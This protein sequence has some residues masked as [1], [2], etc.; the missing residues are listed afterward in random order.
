MNASNL[1]HKDFVP[2]YQTLTWVFFTFVLI[3]IFW[4]EI[5]QVL[6]VLMRRIEA[7]AKLKIGILDIGEP[8]SSLERDKVGA[9]TTEGKS[10]EPAPK[11]IQNLLR[12]KN[13][14]ECILETHY[15]IHAAEI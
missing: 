13:Y 15:L 4:A 12:E 14:P 3:A 1:L 6:R 7:G 9:A 10:G 8:P 11:D 5:N 2:L